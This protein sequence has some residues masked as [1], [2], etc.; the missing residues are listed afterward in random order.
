MAFLFLDR[1]PAL[2]QERGA[3]LRISVVAPRC[4]C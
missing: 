4:G 2:Q 1:K 3:A